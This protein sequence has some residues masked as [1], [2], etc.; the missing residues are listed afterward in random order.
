MYSD[1]KL[2]SM[3][4]QACRRAGKACFSTPPAVPPQ[5]P[6]GCFWLC[7]AITTKMNDENKN[8]K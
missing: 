6:A 3:S 1:E 4:L 2:T 8:K 5:V 7:G